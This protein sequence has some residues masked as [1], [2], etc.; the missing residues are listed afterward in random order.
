MD[1]A[2]FLNKN[3]IKATSTRVQL[4][5]ILS[6]NPYPLQAKEIEE[7]WDSKIDR[8]TLYRTLKTLV[9]KNIIHKIEVNELIT[10]YNFFNPEE[11]EDHNPDHAHFHCNKCEKVICLH[12]YVNETKPLPNGYIQSK[13][14]IVIEG[15]CKFCN[16]NIKNTKEKD[17]H[18]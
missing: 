10:C 8:V 13:T 5:E 9:A 7:K 11:I 16:T 17:T 12:D 18:E 4:L 15:V 1:I 6:S 14:N 2:D 3:K